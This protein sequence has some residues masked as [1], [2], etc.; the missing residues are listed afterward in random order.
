MFINRDRGESGDRIPGFL[1][2]R[3]WLVKDNV[4]H[5]VRI[6]CIGA[7]IIGSSP[8]KARAQFATDTSIAETC[9]AAN[10]NL[11]LGARLPHAE[12]RFKSGQPLKIV[13]IGSSSTA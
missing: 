8:E 10:S 6:A 1:S 12:A 7:A 3:W 9:L 4:W 13:E 5:A 2:S 11:S